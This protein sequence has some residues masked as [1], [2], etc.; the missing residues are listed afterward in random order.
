MG[1]DEGSGTG[2]V[3]GAFLARTK[4]SAKHAAGRVEARY[5]DLADRARLAGKPLRSRS[6]KSRQAWRNDPVRDG[7]IF[8][9]INE[10]LRS[11]QPLRIT[12]KS[13]HTVSAARKTLADARRAGVGVI[14]DLG[15]P[16]WD[17]A[18]GLLKMV[19][20]GLASWELGA[21][22][23]TLHIS[24]DIQKAA[25][26]DRRGVGRYLQDRI[27]RHLRQVIPGETPAFWFAVEQGVWDEPHI[28]GAV[29]IPGG[30]E[31]TVGAALRAAGGQWKSTSR[32][33]HFSRRGNLLTW[34]GYSTKWLYGSKV[35][36]RSDNLTGASQAMR[37][38]AKAMYQGARKRALSLYP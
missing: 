8:S 15:L 7:K 23:F 25:A 14:P 28:H 9:Y 6:E 37:R 35:K 22:P 18:S 16:N 33:V 1:A 19:G 2:G 4:R 34:V 30:M 17:H 31:G 32:Q 24:E 13:A 29:V 26:G 10:K 5:R 11:G 38:M 27:A 3:A 21:T 12:D 36:L 20:W